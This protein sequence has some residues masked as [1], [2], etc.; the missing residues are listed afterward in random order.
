MRRQ[1]TERRET[2]ASGA[3]FVESVYIKL[4]CLPTEASLLRPTEL[5]CPPG[6]HARLLIR[7]FKALFFL[8]GDREEPLELRV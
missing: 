6:I 4:T 3:S 1:W 8:M 5:G 2:E 7:G